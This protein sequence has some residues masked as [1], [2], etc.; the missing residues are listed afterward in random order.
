MNP[1][2]PRTGGDAPTVDRLRADIDEGRTGE[3]IAYPDPA[4]APLGADDEA[5]GTPPTAEQRRQELENRPEGKAQ[6]RKE[7]GSLL[8]YGLLIVGIG[9][10]VV[11][12]LVL[13]QT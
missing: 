4:A 12:A 13:F 6:T 8:L 3:K 5:A 7:P 9:F 10:V 2:K 11:A 1:P